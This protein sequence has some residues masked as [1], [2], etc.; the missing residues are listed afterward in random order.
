MERLRHQ[1][2]RHAGRR[3]GGPQRHRLPHR[4]AATN[5]R[6]S[7]DDPAD[8]EPVMA[9]SFSSLLPE[10]SNKSSVVSRPPG[11]RATPRTCGRAP[12]GAPSLL[13]M[14]G[15][16]G[17]SA[18]DR[19]R[20][21]PGPS[22]PGW[23]VATTI[24]AGLWAVVPMGHLSDQSN[25]FWQLVHTPVGSGTHGG[26]HPAGGGRQRRPGRPARRPGSVLAGIVPSERSTFRRSPER[27]RGNRHG[28]ASYRRAW[29]PFPTRWHRIGR[30]TCALCAAGGVLRRGGRRHGPGGSTAVL[31]QPLPAAQR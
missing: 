4:P 1:R 15:G 19:A 24:Q 27:G 28:P 29:P 17:R 10:P 14:R 13:A 5:G 18:G 8:G 21:P 20:R 3:H 25:T 11:V 23:R 31:R 2:F 16:S 6:R 30:A 9:S 22:H 7:I 26:R 12:L